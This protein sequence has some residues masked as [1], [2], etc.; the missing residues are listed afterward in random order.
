MVGESGARRASLVSSD[1]GV[2]SRLASQ[3]AV[4]FGV[5]RAVRGT[6]KTKRPRPLHPPN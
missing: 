4:G 3:E 5:G 6:E 2:G 1:S